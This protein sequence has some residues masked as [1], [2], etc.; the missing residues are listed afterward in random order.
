MT[1]E[2]LIETAKSVSERLLLTTTTSIGGVGSALIARNGKVYKGRNIDCACGIGFCAE[3]SAIAAMITDG[4][5]EIEK[6][7]AVAADGD[8]IPPCGRCRELIAQ[9]NIKNQD[10]IVLLSEN[11]EVELKTLLPHSWFEK[12]Q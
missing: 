9:V 6:I 5:S 1:N 4:E 2:K 7:V 12:Y 11:E 8:V 10:T 3:H